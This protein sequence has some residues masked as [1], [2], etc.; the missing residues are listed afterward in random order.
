ML[1]MSHAHPNYFDFK[2]F[3]AEKFMTNSSEYISIPQLVRDFAF[4]IDIQGQGYSGRTKYLLYSNRPLFY[5]ERVFVEYF[6]IELV[7]YYHYI[8]VKN[9]LS[10]LVSQYLWAL[11][12]PVKVA[13]IAQNALNYAKANMTHS[14]FIDKIAETFLYMLSEN[15]TVRN[16]RLR[17]LQD[18]AMELDCVKFG[19]GPHLSF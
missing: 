6:N 17:R 9:D 4:L 11:D 7:P 15:N 14:V 8:P 12:N 19:N 13:Q 1:H 16:R 10:D 3:P 2:H 18:E 5:V